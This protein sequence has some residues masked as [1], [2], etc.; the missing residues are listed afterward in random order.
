MPWDSRSGARPTAA[1]PSRSSR[2][3]RAATTTTS[4]GSIPTHPITSIAGQRPGHGGHRQR[5]PS[6]SSWYNQPTGQFYHLATDDRF[7]YWI[8]SGQ[9]DSG[10]VGDRQPQRLRR[11]HL[12]RLASGRR[13][14]A[15]L[16]HPR[17]R[18]SRHRLRHRPRRPAVALGR[19]APGRCRTSRPGRSPATASGR[20]TVQLPLH[21]D[22]AARRLA[23]PPH[24][25]YLG[26]Q[27][28]FRST[29]RGEHW[30][31]ISPRPDRHRAGRARLRRRPAPSAAPGR[32]A[33]A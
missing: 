33:T 10:T 3:R 29:D 7:P 11:D 31:T 30:E 8:Y 26:P 15:R 25:L 9:Q 20:P 19:A 1:R 2:A 22:H 21:L 14:R 12:P 18:R 5:R 16:R 17:P 32:A 24:A 4:S 13:R 23:A 6:W 28:L 27:V